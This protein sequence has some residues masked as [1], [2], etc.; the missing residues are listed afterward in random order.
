MG[1]HSEYS[2]RG[3]RET[4]RT[5]LLESGA[6]EPFLAGGFVEIGEELGLFVVMMLIHTVVPGYA[7]ACKVQLVRPRYSWGLLVDAV[8]AADKGIVAQC[9]MRGLNCEWVGLE[10]FVRAI[11]HNLSW[12]LKVTYL[13]C[14]KLRSGYH[15]QR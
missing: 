5:M 7:V 4:P 12:T 15:R 3:V 6:H 14:L 8:E 13:A 2:L 11:F 1:Q 9:H 10:Y